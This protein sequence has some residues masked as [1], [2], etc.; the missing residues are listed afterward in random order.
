MPSKKLQVTS[1][2]SRVK[3][4]KAVTVGKTV[5]TKKNTAGLTVDVYDTR[6]KVV[7]KMHLP[8]DIFGVDVNQQLIAQAVR[9]Y[10]ANK[11]QGTVSTKTRGEVTGSTRKIYRQKGTGR[12]R[13]GSIRA[14]IFVH[15]G[16]VF[17]PKPRD[18][19]MKFP[20]KMRKAALASALSD[21]LTKGQI[22]VLSGLAKI[23]PKTKAMVAVF[24]MLSFPEKNTKVMLVV[25][26]ETAHVIRAARNIEGVMY[27]APQMMTTYDVMNHNAIVFM[28]ETIE[29]LIKRFAGEKN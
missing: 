26:K 11:R 14:P 3:T 15:G 7:E 22:I 29:D 21:K 23:E 4:T 10:L 12:A 8:K 16:L 27:T 17:G 20:K 9:V 6:G 24:E 13:H 19:S 1:D 2:K 25:G 28:K 5:A 18:Y